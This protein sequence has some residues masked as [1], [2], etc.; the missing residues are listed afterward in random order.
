MGFLDILRG[1]RELKQ[2]APDRLFAMSTAY[3]KMEMELSLKSSGKAAIGWAGTL[4]TRA[5]SRYREFAADA[6]AVRLTG[7]PAALASALIKVSD[8]IVGIP[9]RD[10][11]SAAV[12]DAFHLLPVADD[13]DSMLPATHP[14]LKARIERLE[15]LEAKL[16]RR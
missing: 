6:G 4:G 9:K 3:V 2:P 11:R 7:S 15:R 1:K 8:G 12:V 14:P 5:L 13:S 10:L 16:Q